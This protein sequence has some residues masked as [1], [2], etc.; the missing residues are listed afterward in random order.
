MTLLSR[1]FVA[2]AFFSSRT[3]SFDASLRAFIYA[4]PYRDQPRTVCAVK[5][6]HTYMQTRR[7]TRTHVS[8]DARAIPT[9]PFTFSL[10]D[11]PSLMHACTRAHMRTLV[12]VRARV[13]LLPL[14]TRM[15]SHLRISP[16]RHAHALVNALGPISLLELI[17]EEMRASGVDWRRLEAALHGLQVHARTHAA[18]DA[19]VGQG[20]V[21]RAR[22]R[23]CGSFCVWVLEC[24]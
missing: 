22:A 8:A 19:V 2:F 9:E 15:P 14:T 7:P 11:A 10:N 17:C 1:V 24:V 16:L 23:V 3:V 5:Y 21:A 6:T 4:C 20:M 12:C 13:R 18:P